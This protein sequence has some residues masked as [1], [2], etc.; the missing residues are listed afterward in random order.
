[1]RMNWDTESDASSSEFSREE[2]QSSE[3]GES[4]P[5]GLRTQH[6]AGNLCRVQGRLVP[7]WDL[8]SPGLL[9]NHQFSVIFI[10]LELRGKCS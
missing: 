1:M 2:V 8:A 4:L 6:L 5:L 7:F 9:M 3:Q 10:S